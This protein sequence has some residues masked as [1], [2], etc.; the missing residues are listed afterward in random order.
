MTAA[1]GVVLVTHNSL[2]WIDRVWNS[3]A[4]QDH[5]LAHIVVVDD[6][7]TDGTRGRVDALAESFRD[8]SI[9]FDL[10]TATS[11]S[12]DT[13]TRIAQNFCQGVLHLQHLDAVILA[14]HDD[15]WHPDRV[16]RQID[17]LRSSTL[18][19]AS[20]GD[21]PHA[22]STLFREF[23]V[24]ADLMEWDARSRVRWVIRRSVATGSA[25]MVVPR[26]LCTD[27][28]FI[29]PRGWLHD[30]WWS[31]LAAC[32]DGLE[33][34]GDAVIDYRLSGSQ[35]V[36]LDPGRQHLGLRDRV[37]ALRAD[38][39]ARFADLRRLRESADPSLRKEFTLQR[40]VRTLTQ[41]P[42]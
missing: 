17:V 19:L 30:R 36:G 27:P 38:D 7:S 37:R 40:L 41:S 35:Q 4:N 2:A 8:S 1:V 11:T 39:I 15:L 32:R 9:R 22:G 10:V 33:L 28:N 42:K 25:S 23:G 29:P 12:R 21:V 14:D 34:Q 31:I 5:P 16:S 3:I 24:P 18:L 6:E 13:T 20:N 26:L